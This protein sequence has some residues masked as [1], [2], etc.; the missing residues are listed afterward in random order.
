MA[1]KYGFQYKPSKWVAFG[2][3]LEGNQVPLASFFRGMSSTMAPAEMQEQQNAY[4]QA[5]IKANHAISQGNYAQASEMVGETD[6]ALARD[7][8]MKQQEQEYL[9]KM[10]GYRERALSER[11]A[12]REAPKGEFG[13]LLEQGGL[14]P[15][16]RQALV[17][18]RLKTLSKTPDALY[19][20][21]QATAAGRGAGE[22]EYAGKLIEEKEGA[23]QRLA[24]QKDLRDF[25]TKASESLSNIAKVENI[26]ASSPEVAG[27]YAPYREA[28]G[29]YGAVGGLNKEDLQK[30]GELQRRVG[31]IKQSL[32]AQAKAMGQSGINTATEIE[33]ATKGVNEDSSVGQLQGA[34][35]VLKEKQN[36]LLK[37]KKA[38]IKPQEQEEIIDYTT[39]I[40]G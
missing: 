21:A 27:A 6:P 12:S 9:N 14:S 25:E 13:Y 20:Q 19:N 29:R 1:D 28:L 15:E 39:L 30:R 33:Q 40:G 32:I 10:L 22:M 26:L 17:N 4:N 34:L 2:K 7:L 16:D 36:Y 38:Q 31:E 11:I 24:E 8:A 3:G 23:K 37:L 18:E 35:E 5:V